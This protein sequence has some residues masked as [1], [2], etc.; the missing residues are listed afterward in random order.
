MYF[1]PSLC[2]D[3]LLKFQK[4]TRKVGRVTLTISAGRLFQDTAPRYEKLF[5]IKF[6]FGLFK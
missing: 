5:F 3:D 6:V 4:N 2:S 1:P